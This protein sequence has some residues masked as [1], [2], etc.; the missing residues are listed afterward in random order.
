VNRRRSALAKTSTSVKDFVP[1]FPVSTFHSLL[2]LYTKLLAGKCLIHIGREGWALAKLSITA[3]ASTASE[4]GF[5]EAAEKARSKISNPKLQEFSGAVSVLFGNSSAGEVIAQVSKLAPKN[6]LFF[7]RHWALANKNRDDTA[8]V[9]EYSIDL[10]VRDTQ[11]TPK[12][13]DLREIATPLPFVADKNRIRNLVSRFDSQ[14]GSVENLG[15]TEDYVRLQL[16]LAHAEIN[17]DFIAASNRVIEVYW[18]INNIQD[19]S[20]KV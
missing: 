16:T 13:R 12:T 4:N 18:H 5:A 9:L 7:L 20:I 6:R 1:L 10:L 3:M 17:Y 2:A 11:Y 8:D 15:T 14:K 19:L